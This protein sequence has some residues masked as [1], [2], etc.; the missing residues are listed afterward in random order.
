MRITHVAAHNWRNFKNV[1][2]AVGSRLLVVGPNAAGK[3]NLLDLFRFLGDVSR[4]GG[5]L[6]AALEKRGGLSKTRC[7][8]ARNNHRG[9]LALEIDLADGEDTLRARRQGRAGRPQQADHRPGDRDPQWPA[10]AVASR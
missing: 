5:G 7:L 2:F 6:A 1:D 8:F 4:R 10:P 3:S 9:E